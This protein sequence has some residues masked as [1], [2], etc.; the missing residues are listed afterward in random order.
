MPSVDG[1][2]PA[3]ELLQGDNPTAAEARLSLTSTVAASRTAIAAAN[4]RVLRVS[5]TT[6][7][8]RTRPTTVRTAATRPA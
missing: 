4:S 3:T 1:P 2:H 5:P 6:D 8:A 7:L